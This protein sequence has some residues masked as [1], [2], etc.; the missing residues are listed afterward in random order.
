MNTLYLIDGFAQFFRAYHAIRTPMTSPVTG[1][2]TNMTYGFVGMLIKLLKNDGLHLKDDQGRVTHVAVALDVGGDHGTFRSQLFPEYKANRDAPPED[3]MPQVN[4]A[5]E[6]LEAIGVPVIGCEGFEADDVLATL[7]S[8]YSEAHPDVRVR[9]ISKDKDLKQLLGLGTPATQM[10]DVHTDILITEDDLK[11]ELGI[12]PDQVIDLLT[13]MGDTADNIPGVNGI[14]IKTA[15]KLLVEHGS[16]DAIIQAAE[17]GAIK[18]KRRENIIAAKEWLPLSKELVTLRH[19]VPVSLDVEAASVEKIDLNKL[20]D[21][22]KEFGFNRY[23]D[24]LKRMISGETSETTPKKTKPKVNQD[25]GFGLFN[26]PS[27]SVASV[28]GV[29]GDYHTVTTKKDLDALVKKLKKAKLIAVDTETTHIRPM[30]AK[31]A[32][33]SVAIESG[34]GYYIPTRAPEGDTHLDETTVI[35]ALRPLL[36]DPA[37]AKVGQNIKYDQII[38]HNCGIR[39]EG[40]IPSDPKSMA[41]DTMIASYVLDASRSSHG[42]DSLSLAFLERNPISIKDLIGT[43]KSQK[44]FDEV[45]LS[46]AGPY[47]AEDADITLQLDQKLLPMIHKEPELEK[48]YRE[49]EMP[50]VEVLAE[51]EINGVLVDKAE[52]NNQE[53]RLQKRIDELIEEINTEAK[54]S[55]ARTFDLNSP[56]QLSEALFNAP[57]DEVEGLGIKPLKKTKTG[58]STNAEVLEK[59]AQDPEIETPIPSLIL[60]YRQLTKLVST[61]LKSLAEDIHPETKRIH[62]SFNQTV[63]A[64]GRLSSSDPNLQNIPIR[65]DIG[66]EIRRAFVAPEGAQLISADYSQ[67]EL[68]ILAHL[69][70]DP[71]LIEAFLAG[72]DIHKAVAAQ[73]N[74]VPLDEVTSEQRSGA[75][76]VNFG[77]VYGVT[78]WGLA[79]RLNIGNSEAAEIIDNYK[80]KFANI[81]SFLDECVQF[82]RSHG[83]VQTM[84]GRRRPIRDIDDRNPQRKALAERMAINTV[85]QGSAADLIKLAMI[86]LHHRI[87]D[88][89]P[90]G[91]LQGTKMILQIHDELVFETPYDHAARARDVIVERMEAAMDLKVPLKVDAHV[92]SNWY[93]GK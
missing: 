32:G 29:D 82:A 37:V 89:K 40:I 33:V 30:W 38:F 76:M 88:A 60:E 20:I 75:K 44:R 57:D 67:I 81:T 46:L 64:T 18:G 6:M 4:R 8:S 85:V 14:G 15:A 43:G 16:L 53:K 52:L 73:I 10:Y 84:L 79:R 77:I 3:L 2:P 35:D 11:E 55:I 78:P 56:K 5:I 19:D 13:L 72:E 71:A 68:R 69:S 27:D 63:A 58:F 42:M 28:E 9:I 50:L 51:L 65:S 1:E 24:E 66:R 54:N 34:E 87:K 90:D 17:D 80:A 22:C 31:L 83:Y 39:L 91:P 70:D 21:Y 7:A 62:A 25:E 86:D 36:E 12:R 23:Q 49:V 41:G 26:Q 47:A 48:L 45:P 59:L 92:S 74:N 93:D 61:Y